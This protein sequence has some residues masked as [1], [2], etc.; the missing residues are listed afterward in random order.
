MPKPKGYC[1]GDVKNQKKRYAIRV[2][3]DKRFYCE[4][5]LTCFVGNYFLNKHKNTIK[6]IKNF[7]QY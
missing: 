7:I 1:K 4:C 5:C 2:R 6:H 3:E